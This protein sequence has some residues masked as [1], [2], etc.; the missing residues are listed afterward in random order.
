M[1]I[2]ARVI[3]VLLVLA[4]VAL[5]QVT[6]KSSGATGDQRLDGTSVPSGDGISVCIQVGLAVKTQDVGDLQHGT[7]RPSALAHQLLDEGALPIDEFLHL[8][9]S[10]GYGGHIAMEFSPDT[11]GAESEKQVRERL[12]EALAY[13]RA[14]LVAVD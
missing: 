13:C 7:G 10:D 6:P 3:G 14:H 1:P 5:E 4:P 11:L 8:L 9:A 2:P 12:T